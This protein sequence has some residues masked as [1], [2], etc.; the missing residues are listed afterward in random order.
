MK[1][2]FVSFFLG[3]L[4]CAS[5]LSVLGCSQ[6]GETSAEGRRRH[7]RVSRINRQEFMK[8][9]DVA[10]LLDGPSRLSDM[11]IP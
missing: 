5:A 8:D 11:R 10:G 6:P 3:I 7:I 1:S 4:L 2:F 9:L